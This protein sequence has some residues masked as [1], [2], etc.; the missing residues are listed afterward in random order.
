MNSVASFNDKGGAGKSTLAA[1]LTIAA[2]HE[3]K[4]TLI[5]DCDVGQNSIHEWASTLREDP[6]PEVRTGT[7]ENIERQLKEAQAEGFNFIMVDAPPKGGQF[8]ARIA[9]LVDHI[10]IPVRASTFDL[11]AMGN[12]CLLYTSP[13]P[14]DPE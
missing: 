7:Y 12:T 4:R 3:N 2:R 13:S 1:Q 8:A 10:L 9:S 14:R 6:L 5:I 11:L